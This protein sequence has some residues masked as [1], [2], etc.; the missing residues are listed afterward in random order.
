[1]KIIPKIPVKFEGR[2]PADFQNTLPYWGFFTKEQLKE[3]K[4]RLLDIDFG[5]YC[6]LAC[7]GCFR[8]SSVVDETRDGDLSHAELLKVID[9][10]RGLGLESVKICGVGEPTENANF[11]D[12]LKEMTDRG[13]GTAIFTKG[14]V[15]G[16]D[17]AAVKY[18]KR[19]RITSALKFAEELYKL[20]TSVM[21]GFHSFDSDIQDGVVGKT[22]HTTIKN[23]ALE[24]LVNAGF[25]S[26]NPTRLGFCNAPVVRKTAGDA[27]EIYTYARKRNIY[28]I[29]AVLMTSGKQIDRKFLDVHDFSDKEKVE[30]WTKIYFWDIEHGI[31]TLGQIREEGISCLPGGHPCNQLTSGLYITAN[32]NVVGCPGYTETQGNVRKESLSEIWARSKTRAVADER[33]NCH[34]PPKDGVTIPED[35]YAKVLENLER[36]HC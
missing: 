6:S 13:I 27:F 34:C 31:Q 10:A 24:N 14:Q 15:L 28:P 2:F 1:M 30:L 36:G 19:H 26:E 16:D 4:L 29:T 12:F 3:V 23:K 22:G 35:L 17:E 9:E 7:P 18:H 20:K 11:L 25:T 8:R 33:F 5:R 21:L 32:G